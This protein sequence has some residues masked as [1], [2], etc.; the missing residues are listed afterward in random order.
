MLFEEAVGRCCSK[1][2]INKN[3]PTFNSVSLLSALL[4]SVHGMH[5]LPIFVHYIRVHMNVY[6]FVRPTAL[7]VGECK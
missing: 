2:L 1:K 7:G 3:A 6:I 5:R 4:R